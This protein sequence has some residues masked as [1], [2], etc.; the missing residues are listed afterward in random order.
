MPLSPVAHY[1]ERHP[2]RTVLAICTLLLVNT[3]IG[4]FAYYKVEKNTDDLRAQATSFAHKQ[5][6][7]SNAARKVV[8]DLLSLAE[9]RVKTINNPHQTKEQK[10]QAL[11]FY[12]D[13]KS[14]IVFIQCPPA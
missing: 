7:S 14:K 4:V 9:N 1:A 13:A 11:Q 12:E 2:N 10:Q 5:C 6:V 3:F 8:Y